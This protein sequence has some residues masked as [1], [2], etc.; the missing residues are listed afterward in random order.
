MQSIAGKA[1]TSSHIKYVSTKVNINALHFF[2]RGRGPDLSI[3]TRSTGLDIWAFTQRNRIS[4]MLCSGTLALCA[5]LGVFGYVP[6]HSRVVIVPGNHLGG[7]SGIHVTI[8]INR[9]SSDIG[10]GCHLV[11]VL[12]RNY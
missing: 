11:T 8:K 6:I 4:R 5:R 2:V 3:A 10:G 9:M 1:M 12:G 7:C